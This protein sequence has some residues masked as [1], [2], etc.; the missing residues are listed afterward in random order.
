MVQDLAGW[1]DDHAEKDLE[2][3]PRGSGQ[4]AP[5][6]RCPL[7]QDLL[8][9][10][11]TTSFWDESQ[12]GTT[13]EKLQF[14]LRQLT[15]LTANSNIRTL[16]LQRCEMKVQD[17]ER[18]A[19]VLAQCPAPAHLDLSGNSDFG[20]AEADKLAGVLGLCREFKS[21]YTSFSVAPWHRVW[22]VWC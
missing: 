17:V 21:C 16:E 14:V 4:D 2:E 22:T 12:H 10:F 19:G 7:E 5:A 1:Q 13:A 3:S 18:L 6:S 15:R 8:R 20:A 11:G 9:R